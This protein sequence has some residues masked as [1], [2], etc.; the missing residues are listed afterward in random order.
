[1][2]AY[3]AHSWELFAIRAWLVGFLVYSITLQPAG[4]AIWPAPTAIASLG[5]LIAMATS[6]GGNELADL[7]GRRRM[8]VIYLISAGVMALFLGFLP[9]LPY[10]LLALL[11]LVYAALVQLDSAALTAGAVMAAETGRRG[12]TLGVHSLIGFSAGALG[13]LVVGVVLDASG[14]GLTTLSWG[15][16]FMSMGAVALL[17]PLAFVFLRPKN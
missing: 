9:G 14:G 8:V 15:L 5:A 1:M 17:G 13:P 6:I 2:L 12:A 7:F 10:W 11:T 16:G 4:G 3:G